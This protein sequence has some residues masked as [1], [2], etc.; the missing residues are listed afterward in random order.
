MNGGQIGRERQV[1]RRVADVNLLRGLADYPV[2]RWDVP[3]GE[4]TASES[5]GPLQALAGIDGGAVECTQ[6][7]NGVILT[8]ERNIL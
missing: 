1:A 2:L 7:A 4:V 3:V 5:G 6:H 8:T